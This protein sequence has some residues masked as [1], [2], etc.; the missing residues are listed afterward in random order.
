MDPIDKPGLG[1]L[2]KACDKNKDV[3]HE[4][5]SYLTFFDSTKN[6][7]ELKDYRKS[8]SV[9]MTNHYYDLSTDFYEYGWGESF[10]FS[11]LSKAESREHSYAKHEYR[12]A[13]K[14]ALGPGDVALVNSSVETRRVEDV[15]LNQITP[16]GVKYFPI[17]D[18]SL[19]TSLPI[20]KYAQALYVHCKALEH[21]TRLY[22]KHQIY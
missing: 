2:M 21:M 17:T 12:L 15:Y 9:Q 18:G 1:G 14:L 10:H 6:E 8:N 16:L 3:C 20:T 22:V 4:A 11:T 5:Q 13:L 7:T 19:M